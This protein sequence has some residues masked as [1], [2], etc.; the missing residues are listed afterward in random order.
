[1]AG[2]TVW[3]PSPLRHTSR[4]TTCRRHGSGRSRQHCAGGR[5]CYGAD[6]AGDRATVAAGP[7]R[8]R[9]QDVGLL[10]SASICVQ[11]SYTESGLVID[12]NPT[13]NLARIYLKRMPMRNF[14]VVRRKGKHYLLL[15]LNLEG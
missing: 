2:R 12:W 1:M 15:Q 9:T 3:T 10:R 8:P 4:A 6:P 13:T 5:R 7:W 14:V 11:Q